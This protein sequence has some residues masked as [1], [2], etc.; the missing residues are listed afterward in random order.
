MCTFLSSAD[1]QRD[2]SYGVRFQPNFQELSHKDF[3]KS[4]RIIRVLK[5]LRG[6][7]EERCYVKRRDRKTVTCTES[8]S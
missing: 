8:A 7:V 4:V 6:S 3:G 2:T 1:P 5:D